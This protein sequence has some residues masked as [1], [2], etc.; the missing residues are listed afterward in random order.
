MEG[1]DIIFNTDTINYISFSLLEG[2]VDIILRALELY[3]YV[4]HFISTKHDDLE[5]LRN[6]LIFHTYN[7]ILSHYT[8][9]KFVTYAGECIINECYNQVNSNK[10][11]RYHVI[12]N[13]LKKIA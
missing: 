13:K 12:K 4:Y 2:Q 11:R 5:D 9:C 6:S 7:E 10:K 3:A 1:G 8:D